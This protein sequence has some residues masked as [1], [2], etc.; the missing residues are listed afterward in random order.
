MTDPVMA[1][2]ACDPQALDDVTLLDL[3]DCCED[4]ASRIEKEM[5]GRS[6]RRG[7]MQG[8]RVEV[9]PGNAAAF[10]WCLFA[11]H[12]GG[13]QL[14]MAAD[15]A[16]EASARKGGLDAAQEFAELV[17]EKDGSRLNLLGLELVNEFSY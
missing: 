1:L 17:Q 4:L 16:D 8:L 9:G 6:E 7:P 10:C 15:A 14:L 13:L 5:D 12:E 2:K 3:L 11:V